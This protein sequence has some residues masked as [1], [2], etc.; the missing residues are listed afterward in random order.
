MLKFK[1]KRLQDFQSKEIGHRYRF[2]IK[3]TNDFSISV[4]IAPNGIVTLGTKGQTWIGFSLLDM[5][6]MIADFRICLG[7]KCIETESSIT[8]S[9]ILEVLAKDFFEAKKKVEAQLSWFNWS[10]FY[11]HMIKRD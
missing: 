9:Q 1:G 10:Y 6:E 2:K 8:T 5:S 3:L 7:F 4:A 11:H